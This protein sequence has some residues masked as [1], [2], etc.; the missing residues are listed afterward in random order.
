MQNK[1]DARFIDLNKAPTKTVASETDYLLASLPTGETRKIPISSVIASSDPTVVLSGEADMDDPATTPTSIKITGDPD[2]AFIS[3]G[4]APVGGRIGAAYLVQ[5]S[6]PVTT[7][8]TG[9][10]FEVRTGNEI[11]WTGTKWSI[12]AEDIGVS[13]VNG[14]DG[15]V[16]LNPIDVK[17]DNLSKVGGNQLQIKT[18][19][20]YG[21]FGMLNG[22]WFHM[23]TDAADGFYMYQNLNAANLA[24]RGQVSSEATAPTLPQHLT[25]KDYVDVKDVNNYKAKGTPKSATLSH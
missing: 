10:A 5:C 23:K 4:K 17:L 8:I 18:G 11:V 19:H 24:S 6:D 15:N 1:I 22:S 7:E 21:Q 16:V 13:T 2:N 12:I 9:K 20:G 14:R 3:V 25:R